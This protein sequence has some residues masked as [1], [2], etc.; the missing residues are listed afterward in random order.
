[1]ADVCSL[2]VELW[3]KIFEFL[4]KVDIKS[5]ASTSH[6][7]RSLAV[8]SLF[9]YI[10]I[11]LGRFG[12]QSAFDGNPVVLSW[13]VDREEEVV[14]RSLDVLLRIAELD[15][16]KLDL[17]NSVQGLRIL[18]A[19]AR[20]MLVFEKRVFVS[21]IP[22]SGVDSCLSRSPLSRLEEYHQPA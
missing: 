18:V 7:L 13:D 4:H 14:G 17:K 9:A 5:F 22:S 20:H 21:I 1:M 16:G 8:P 2:P 10:R 3:H 12:D 11:R 15:D 6:Y 19:D